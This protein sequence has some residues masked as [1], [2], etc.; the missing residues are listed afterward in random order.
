MPARPGE[1]SYYT[2][3]KLQ[4][5]ASSCISLVDLKTG[6]PETRRLIRSHVMLGKNRTKSYHAKR[7]SVMASGTRGDVP[8]I[9]SP[10]SP[11][12]LI[13]ASYSVMRRRVGSDISFANF[14]VEIGPAKWGDL[15]R[16]QFFFLTIPRIL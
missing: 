9:A 4:R 1:P 11:D 12:E 13:N 7:R 16:C 5:R 14:P 15:L 10:I 2:L 6:D 3:A 8:S